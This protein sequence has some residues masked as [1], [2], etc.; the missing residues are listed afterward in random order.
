MSPYEIM[1]ILHCYTSPTPYRESPAREG[2]I[3]KFLN[4]NV[5][6]KEEDYFICTELGKAYVEI[7]MDAP[8]PEI[9]YINPDTEEII[10]VPNTYSDRGKN[11]QCLL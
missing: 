4:L 1:F 3:K 8:L 11:N 5:I 2:A 9:A 6:I 10:N 7:L